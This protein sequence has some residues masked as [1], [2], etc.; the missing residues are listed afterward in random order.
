MPTAKK[1]L[2]A[3]NASHAK[4]SKSGAKTAPDTDINASELATTNT[5][6]KASSKSKSAK[7][8]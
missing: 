6:V 2:T 8:D 4:T 7:D 1:T 5:A 3:T